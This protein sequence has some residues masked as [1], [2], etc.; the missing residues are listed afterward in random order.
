[1]VAC[2]TANNI[3]SA[4]DDI[5]AGSKCGAETIVGDITWTASFTGFY[6]KT[7]DTDQISGAGLIDMYQAKEEHEWRMQNAD[8]TY[9]R[10][11]TGTLANYSE[12]VDYNTAAEFSS[13]INIR[14]AL[15]TEAPEE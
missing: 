10:G 11:F 9:Y 6:E 7:P 15:I 13:D 5:D 12:T 8:Q 14:G 1:M 4:S 2:I 3:D